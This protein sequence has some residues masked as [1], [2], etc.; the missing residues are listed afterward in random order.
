MG[1]STATLPHAL[2]L[3]TVKE[4]TRSLPMK[5]HPLAFLHVIVFLCLGIALGQQPP[6][7]QA[8]PT[9][10]S[11]THAATPPSPGS[12]KNSQPVLAPPPANPKAEA[13]AAPPPPKLTPDDA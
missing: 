2:W 12:Q 9:P 3:Y 1:Q 11:Q 6:T 10:S 4:L 13:D 8:S 7:P 5:R